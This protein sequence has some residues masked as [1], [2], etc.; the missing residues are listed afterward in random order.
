MIKS[1]R[2][3]SYEGT[4]AKVTSYGVV[5]PVGNPNDIIGSTVNTYNLSNKQGW[6]VNKINSNDQD[7]FVDEFIEKESKWFNYIQ[8]TKKS[9]DLSTNYVSQH[10]GDFSFQGIG[11][12]SIIEQ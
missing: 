9:N 10:T 6:Y 3:L 5:A 4:Q 11:E 2:T 7:G 8:G 1:F 12:A